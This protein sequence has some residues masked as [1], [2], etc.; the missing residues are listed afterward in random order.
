MIDDAGIAPDGLGSRIA[1]ETTVGRNKQL[2]AFVN[3]R[4]IICAVPAIEN[5]G[6][7][8]TASPT[9]YATFKFASD[10]FRPTEMRGC[11]KGRSVNQ[12]FKPTGD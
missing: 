4:K 3:L 11:L 1:F 8:G 2:I 9:F 12:D 6:Y 10:L 5:L 7:A